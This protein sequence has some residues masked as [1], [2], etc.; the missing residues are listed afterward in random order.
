MNLKLIKK[1]KVIILLKYQ[2]P[3]D[4]EGFDKAMKAFED[5]A[6]REKI[7]RYNNQFN[8]GIPVVKE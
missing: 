6:Y 4:E 7:Y 3:S 1:K 5:S 2:N 8:I